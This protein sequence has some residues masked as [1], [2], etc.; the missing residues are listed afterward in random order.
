[1]DRFIRDFRR[2]PDGDLML[3]ERFGVAYQADMTVTCEYD[4]D[5]WQK[6][7]NYEGSEIANKLNAGRR[8]IVHKYFGDG[9]VLD[10]GIG[11]GEFIKGRPNTY[12]TD[13]NPVAVEWLK[14]CGLYRDDFENFSGFTF[15]D[16]IEHCPDPGVYLD[17]MPDGAYAFFSIPVFH[18]LKRI[19][20]SKHY[21]PGE[22][23][24][25]WTPIGFAAWL[26]MHGFKF[27]DVQDFETQA[28]REEILTFAAVKHGH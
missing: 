27:L 17:R 20:E 10:V 8:S 14:D 5:Y 11:C 23:L 22:H 24:Y 6:L 15:W 13:V 2:E 28:G 3:C 18:D 7:A 16:V 26:E 12:G 4:G 9:P 1:M 19:R 25:Y 21:R